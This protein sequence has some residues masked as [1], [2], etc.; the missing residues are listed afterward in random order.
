MCLN[1]YQTGSKELAL[2]HIRTTGENWDLHCLSILKRNTLARI[3]YL[4]D[5]YKKIL[6]K[7]GVVCEFG[8]Q[9]GA[10]LSTLMNLRSIYEPYNG[11]RTIFG[12]DTFQGFADLHDNDGN[13]SITDLDDD[14]LLRTLMEKDISKNNDSYKMKK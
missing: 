14:E 9:W 4:D 5:I 13:F 12:F 3:L 10:T 8:V 2:E 11:S 1:F 6:D 7:P